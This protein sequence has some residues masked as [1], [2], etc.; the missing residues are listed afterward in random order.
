[1]TLV[2]EAD[3]ECDLRQ[4]ELTVCPQEVL[5][6][7]NAARHLRHEQLFVRSRHGQTQFYPSP[8][9]GVHELCRTRRDSFGL[10]QE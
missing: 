4:T 6:S 2:R 9:G 10:P 1:M 7:F 8:D 3:A 5:R